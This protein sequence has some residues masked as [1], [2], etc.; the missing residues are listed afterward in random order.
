[1]DRLPELKEKLRKLI[2]RQPM[3]N[4]FPTWPWDEQDFKEVVWIIE[5]FVNQNEDQD[6]DNELRDWLDAYQFYK[7]TRGSV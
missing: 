1:M 4:I 2:S 3:V 5:D 6:K 7:S